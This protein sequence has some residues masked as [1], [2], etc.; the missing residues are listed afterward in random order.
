MNSFKLEIPGIL[1]TLLAISALAAIVILQ[2]TH[3][4]T[5]TIDDGLFMLLGGAGGHGLGR[6]YTRPV[7]TFNT[8]STK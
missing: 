6:G 3:T 1:E 5:S 8:G 2:V 7:K 4:G